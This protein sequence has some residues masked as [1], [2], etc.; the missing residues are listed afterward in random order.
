M[1]LPTPSNPLV[2]S[3]LMPST[4]ARVFAALTDARQMQQWF[5][6]HAHVEQR[7]GGAYRFWGRHTA[8]IHREQDSDGRITAIDPGRGLTYAFTWRNTKCEVSLR[9]EDA[10]PGT[11]RLHVRMFAPEPRMGFADECAWYMLDFWRYSSGNLRSYLATGAAALMPDF[12]GKADGVDMSI[13]VAAPPERVYAAL[14]DPAKMDRWVSTKAKVE[15]RAG[16][17][18]TFGWMIKDS[19][20]GETPC[21]P[22]R[23]VELVPNRLIVHDWSHRN[24]PRTIVRWELTPEGAGTRVRLTHNVAASEPMRG[25]YVG[26]WTSYLVELSEFAAGS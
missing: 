9:V 13:F 16:G 19:S 15:P 21:G 26:G 4:T 14:T 3:Y 5:A 18:Y 2:T 23:F 1:T 8:W 6:E 11:S 7:E 25:G 24:E 17:E 10:E 12:Q 20:G 22:Q